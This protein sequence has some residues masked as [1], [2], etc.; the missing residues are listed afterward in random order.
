MGYRSDVEAVFYTKKDDLPVLKLWL[1]ENFPMVEFAEDIHWFNKMNYRGM[2][3][4]MRGVKWY[5]GFPSVRAFDDAVSKF[6]E[7]FCSD[8]GVEHH[9]A[10]E[11]VRIGEDY[12]DIEVDRDGDH[13]YILDVHQKIT[14][15]V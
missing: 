11:F 5:D 2:A 13:E 4:K 14:S 12:N 9:F 3:V 10:Y 15:E 1:D 6:R 8:L 7:M